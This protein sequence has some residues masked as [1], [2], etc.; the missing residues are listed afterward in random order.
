M[1]LCLCQLIS[2]TKAHVVAYLYHCVNE[3]D[4]VFVCLRGFEYLSALVNLFK[5]V[6]SLR[7][8]P[9]TLGVVEAVCSTFDSLAMS[10][11]IP[12][13]TV[14]F[15]G[16][17]QLYCTMDFMD[18]TD[19]SAALLSLMSLG[20]PTGT[21]ILKLSHPHLLYTPTKNGCSAQSLCCTIA[22]QWT[23]PPQWNV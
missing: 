19:L 3:P 15:L 21:N 2:P 1:C 23:E 16:R 14:W 10:Q 9:P 22:I 7:C 8:L 11:V 6:E 20:A 5:S 18:H 12:A 4:H 17:N 13:C